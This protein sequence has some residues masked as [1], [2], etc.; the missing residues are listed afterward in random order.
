MHSAM[1]MFEVQAA[2]LRASQAEQQRCIDQY[3][4]TPTHTPNTVGTRIAG[5]EIAEYR[6]TIREQKDVVQQLIATVQQ[7]Y[8]QHEQTRTEWQAWRVATHNEI[9][10]LRATIDRMQQRAQVQEA[11]IEQLLMPT[12]QAQFEGQFNA[13]SQSAPQI[14]QLKREFETLQSRVV[15]DS[16]IESGLSN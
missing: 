1:Q 11:R 13:P 14:D 8:H 9:D 6:A 7:Q 2:E 3:L 4:S 16:H 12:T 10:E 5:D 15:D